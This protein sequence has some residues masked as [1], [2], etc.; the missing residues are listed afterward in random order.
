M[1]DA[2]YI[3]K[4]YCWTT[5]VLFVLFTIAIIVSAYLTFCKCICCLSF[6]VIILLFGDVVLA[7]S[8]IIS[9]I[10]MYREISRFQARKFAT[11]MKK[12]LKK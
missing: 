11:D 1:S 7:L 10:A 3:K 5:G 6:G 12:S 9:L 2:N 4:Y 8:C